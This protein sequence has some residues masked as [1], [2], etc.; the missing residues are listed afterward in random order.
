[1]WQIALMAAG[2]LI[3]AN[4]TL[5]QGQAEH[6]AAN[7]QAKILERQA[8]Q[9]L[10]ASARGAYNIRRAGKMAQ[11]EARGEYAVA[12]VDVGAGS[13]QLVQSDIFRRSEIDARTALLEGKQQATALQDE[14]AFKRWSGDMARQ[15][16][17]QQAMSDVLGTGAGIAKNWSTK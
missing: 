3:K 11:S 6:D 13:A 2:A 9:V 12:G 8:G 16:S 7:W 5:K 17:R 14:A 10:Q 4:A 1:M 15:A